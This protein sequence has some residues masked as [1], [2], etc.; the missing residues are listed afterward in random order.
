MHCF[1]VLLCYLCTVLIKSGKKE[2]CLAA[3]DIRVIIESIVRLK[4]TSEVLN[5]IYNLYVSYILRRN[6]GKHF[7]GE[8]DHN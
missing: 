8:L 6:L 5:R 1:Y 3:L 2:L 7:S 4:V